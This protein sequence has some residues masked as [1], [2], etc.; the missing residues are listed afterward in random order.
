[1]PY[2]PSMYIADYVNMTFA[3]EVFLAHQRLPSATN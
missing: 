2:S 1:M 3:G